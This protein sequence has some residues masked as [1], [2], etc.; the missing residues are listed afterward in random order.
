MFLLFIFAHDLCRIGLGFELQ[1]AEF[2]L[3]NEDTTAKVAIDGR[4]HPEWHFEI[5]KL[6][7]DHVA[8]VAYGPPKEADDSC[9]YIN[10]GAEVGDPQQMTR[11]GFALLSFEELIEGMTPLN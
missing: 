1:R 2:T 4:E 9:N 10:R 6:G 3:E 11:L 8:S 7:S 5:H